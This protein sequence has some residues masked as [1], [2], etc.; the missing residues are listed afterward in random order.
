MPEENG[1]EVECIRV[2]VSS[3][4]WELD[5]NQFYEDLDLIA[6]AADKYQ[7]K[8][9]YDKSSMGVFLLDW[10]RNREA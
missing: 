1:F 8:R 10:I 7:I 5:L 4:S 6:Q 2:T 9:I 3:E